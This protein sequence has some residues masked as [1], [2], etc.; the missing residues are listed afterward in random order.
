[1]KKRQNKGTFFP[2]RFRKIFLIMKLC[3]FFTLSLTFAGLAS[4]YS[5]NGTLSLKINSGNLSDALIQIKDATGI[6]II[7][8]ET[9]LEEIKCKKL[10]FNE[11]KVKS[12]IDRLLEESGL[13]CELVDEVYIIKRV[14]R[15]K[16]ITQRTVSGKVTDRQGN[17]LPGVG[18]IIEGTS[19]G[20]STNT[21]GEYTLK[22]PDIPNLTLIFSFIGMKTQRE[23]VGSRTQIDVRMEEDVKEMEEVIVT[24]Y[25][26]ILKERATGSF[27]T[28]TSEHIEAKLQP[29]LT[30]ILE[31]M[32]SG[33]VVDRKGNIEI[34]GISTFN[35]EKEPLLVVDGYPI[36]G[37]IE[38][39]N[40]DNIENITVLKDGV[41]A[42]IYGS[43]AANGVIVITTKR[44]KAGTLN[45]SYKGNF[46]VTLKP[47]LS[48][49]NRVSTEGYID[50]ELDFYN[51]NPNSP[52]MTDRNPMGR[53]TY[54]MMMV[55]ENRLS[56]AEAMAE[57]EE[58][59][60]VDGLQ[61]VEDNFFRN[62]LTHKHNLMISGGSETNLFNAAINYTG[63]RGD[64]IHTKNSRLILDLN[65]EW[66]PNKYVSFGA[67]AN[68]VFRKD[69]TPYQSYADIL[70]W[71][72]SSLIQPYDNL[73]DPETG[74]PTTI[75][76]T[77]PYKI[78][79]YE[80]TPG[81]KDWTYNPIENIGKEMTTN[82]NFQARIGGKLKI[83]LLEGLNL[84][85]GG[86]WT[87]GN[88]KSQTIHDRD[89]YTVR[90][91]YNDATSIKNNADHY[92]PDGAVVDE[93]RAVNESYTL[94]TQ[95]NF[96]R[97]FQQD[98]HR[99]MFLAG[100]EIR[101]ST[102]DNN[103]YAT[104]LGY[105]PTAGSF[106]PV[107]L[108]DYKAGNYNSDML[109]RPQF[110]YS[111]LK[112][113]SYS[114]SDNRFV[115]WYANGS[116]EYDNRFI[117][118]GSIRLDLTNFFGT[119]P[120][121]RYKPLWSVGGTWKIKNEKFMDAIDWLN[122]LNIRASY[123]VNGNIALN[124]GPFMILQV[125]NYNNVTGGISYSISS[126][127]NEQLR[128]EKTRS[129][130]I[131]I[132]AAF[133]NNRINLTLDYYY[134]N[135]TDLLANDTN[136]P[137]TGFPSLMKNVGKMSNNGIE[138][139][140]GADIIRNENFR[141]NA[142]Y[143]LSHNFNKV[144]KY[145]VTR[146]YATNWTGSPKLVEGKP[147]D[148]IYA[149]R[150]AGLN[151]QGHALCYN[152]AGEKIAMS[153]AQAEDLIYAG[154]TRP[155][156]DMSFT[157]SFTW[158]NFNLSCMFIAKLG[159]KYRK[160]SFSGTNYLNRH[161]TER[162][163]EPGD[164]AT[165]IYPRLQRYSSDRFYFPYSDFL[166]GKAN[167]LKLRDVTLTYRLPE[168][169]VSSVGLTNAKLYF[170]ARNLFTVTAKGVDIDPE[171]AEM[172]ESGATYDFTEQ[173][174]TSLPKRAEFYMGLS[175]T[176]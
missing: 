176:F 170:Q 127:A 29:D 149:Y 113:G 174:Y 150:Y 69:E 95:V 89:S 134:K 167:Y 33:V 64:Y 110:H 156:F 164:E 105:N 106:I 12:A 71:E 121:Y 19:T 3:T 45:V 141:W 94:R 160:D 96:N 172:N 7:Y 124:Q 147:A 133:L 90:I 139:S 151:D 78:S 137:T 34:R 165:K 15:N 68:I 107:N 18:I 175:F 155:K 62:H 27:S 26:T 1:M 11:E 128:W 144:K 111:S 171:G 10:I 14:P 84:E 2:P 100:N 63:E 60:K 120:D 91:A 43:R 23:T 46:G 129:T 37:D 59:K 152:A 81:M 72:S 25:Q 30:S 56:E 13:Y 123:G 145:N 47:D 22:C 6:Q 116:Y 67:Q 109:F 142:H 112:T 117:I 58:L 75:F 79:T 86:S 154:T 122:R 88:E 70:A 162:W 42:S 16:E 49:L 28:I 93:S 80:V 20:T 36:E 157:N 85:V 131:G 138:I 108:K 101:R 148:A 54:L 50:A 136:D 41:A 77:S 153:A 114:Y 119:D 24:G 4:V 31:G 17:P 166:I 83:N 61:Q 168:K 51:Q 159:H 52:S 74:R 98:K 143:N 73:I 5:Q 125:G 32:M 38:S 92:F 163:R 103:V 115:S 40:P 82:E 55:R 53:V 102:Y 99:I 35:A 76:S 135:S 44:G 57:I 65:N 161:V 8:N 97:N 9:Q 118:S 39:I 104:R 130:N 48:A 132:D 87:R 173:G 126:P 140:L 169:L 158:K 146:L 66:T 21:D